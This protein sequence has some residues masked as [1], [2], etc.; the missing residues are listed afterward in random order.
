MSYV[1]AEAIE[2]Y[3]GL[4]VCAA[5]NESKNNDFEE[6]YPASY[7]LP[8]MI[9]VGASTKEDVM[10]SGSNY[11]KVTVDIF[12]PGLDILTTFVDGTCNYTYGTSLAA[13]FV[14]GVAALLLSEY[15]N[16][17][18]EQLKSTILA[19]VAIVFLKHVVGWT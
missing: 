16:M 8:N 11:G 1:L 5:G 2:G 17:T 9:T 6:I 15:P 12:A 18:A 4:F 7:T 13:P 14:A 19:C 3:S 10:W